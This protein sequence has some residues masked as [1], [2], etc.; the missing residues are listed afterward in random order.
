MTPAR[1][2]ALVPR[3]RVHVT[4]FRGVFAP[5]NHLW[6]HQVLDRTCTR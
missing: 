1:R 6:L 3:P 2:A 4:R 5:N